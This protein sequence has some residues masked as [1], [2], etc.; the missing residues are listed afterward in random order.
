MAIA[1]I[2]SHQDATPFTGT[3]IHQPSEA[4]QPPRETPIVL[5]I[6]RPAELAPRGPITVIFWMVEPWGVAPSQRLLARPHAVDHHIVL[7]FGGILTTLAGWVGVDT[8]GP[9]SLY[10]VS[11]SRIS[12]PTP[13]Q[14]AVSTTPNWDFGRKTFACRRSP[15][16]FGYAG[17]VLFPSQTL[18]QLT[19]LI[20]NR[21]VSLA[22]DNPLCKL[23]WIT[24]SLEASC[25]GYP[26][27]A[28][29]NFE[30]L[31]C[32]RLNELMSCSFYA[33]RLAFRKGVLTEQTQ[34]EIPKTSGPLT[35][36]DSE[37][38]FAF[39]SGR[40]N[41]KEHW[42]RWS[43]TDVCGTSRSVFSAFSDHLK[44]GKDLA[45]GGA[46]QLVGLYRKGPANA[47]GIIW[48]Q[49]RFLGGME[50]FSV[51]DESRLKWHNDLFEICD[52]KTLGRDQSAQPQPRPPSL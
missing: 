46:P 25:R 26:L 30:V 52:A 6:V 40:D 32:G 47:F 34:I 17:A 13:G 20:D 23:A 31:Y 19:E 44:S 51:S 1:A 18:G 10:L 38:R 9:A 50:V 33:F 14:A 29:L 24:E 27:T 15:E 42:I 37:E 5:P 39:G 48:N 28:E 22:H 4:S 21:A 7:L 36:A 8:R 43:A 45:T 3:E 11:D 41:F 35:Y 2:R 49:R 16:I 12:W